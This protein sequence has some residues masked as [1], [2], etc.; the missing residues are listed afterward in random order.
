MLAFLI[1][2]SYLG[3]GGT[4]LQ[5][6][7]TDDAAGGK[8]LLSRWLVGYRLVLLVLLIAVWDVVFKPGLWRRRLV[9]Q[10]KVNWSRLGR[11]GA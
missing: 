5:R 4:Q 11:R 10:R 9:L 2:A 7:G 8:L 3:R 1:G 6:L